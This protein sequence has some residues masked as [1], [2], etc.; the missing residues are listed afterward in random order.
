MVLLTEFGR[1]IQLQ[2]RPY[3]WKCGGQMYL[4]RP[5]PDQDWEAFWGCSLFPDCDGTLQI[6]PHTGEPEIPKNRW[7]TETR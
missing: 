2:P 4:R 1:E 7:V 5:K 3:C 6:D